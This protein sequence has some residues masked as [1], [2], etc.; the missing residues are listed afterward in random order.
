MRSPC[1]T[2][3]VAESFCY[4]IMCPSEQQRGL[5]KVLEIIPGLTRKLKGKLYD[6][7]VFTRYSSPVFPTRKLLPFL[8]DPAESKSQNIH[9]EPDTL[10]GP[11]DRTLDF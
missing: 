1:A 8:R 4:D 2:D 7:P 11:V 5:M 10:L 6:S 9:Q 3:E